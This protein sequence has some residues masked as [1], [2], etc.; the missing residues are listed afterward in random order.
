MA[1]LDLLICIALNAYLVLVFR[2]FGQRKLPLLPV[3]TVNYWIC[4]ICSFSLLPEPLT[5]IWA[6]SPDWLP[7]VGL[8]GCFF[9]GTFYLVGLCSYRLGA[10]YTGMIAKLSVV[11]PT[12]VS[13]FLFGE[14]LDSLQW[15]GFLLALL[16]IVVLH[17]DV[18]LPRYFKGASN[19][20]QAPKQA[21]ALVPLLFLGA[22]VVDSNFKFFDAWFRVELPPEAFML[23]VF[24]V[25][26]SIGTVWVVFTRKLE[27]NWSSIAI[28]GFVLGIPNF[29]S[30]WFLLRALNSMPGSLFYPLNNMGQLL[31]MV[32]GGALLFHEALKW[33]TWV[34]LVLALLS[35]L[36]MSHQEIWSA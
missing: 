14:S 9:I 12:M 16:T 30:L 25:A 36:L 24:I 19:Q 32:F 1:S 33:Y 26:A 29:F 18:V 22:G 5:T 21:Y 7:L 2:A 20:G 35:L 34:G 6:R 11:L 10:G 8:Q 31:L 13:L 27:W 23:L 28:A 17:L 4:A 15:L 3:I